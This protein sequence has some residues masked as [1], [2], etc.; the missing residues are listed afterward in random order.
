MCPASIP[1]ARDSR[2]KPVWMTGIGIELFFSLLPACVL[3]TR[4]T[5]VQAALREAIRG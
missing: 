3:T 4:D 2:R 5:A 1:A